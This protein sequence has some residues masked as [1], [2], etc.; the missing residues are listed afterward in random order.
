MKYL[1][2][3]DL[4]NIAQTLKWEIQRDCE[5]S[6]DPSWIYASSVALSRVI[7]ELGLQANPF[8]EEDWK[9]IVGE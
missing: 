8:N 1:T 2:P 6:T 4:K 5:E 3:T 9:L 7:D